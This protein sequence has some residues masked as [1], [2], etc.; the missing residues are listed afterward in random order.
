MELIVA[1]STGK[2]TW[3]QV[4]KLIADMEWTKIILNTNNFGKENYTC[5]KPAE[6]I[7]LDDHAPLEDMRDALIKELKTKVE[8]SEVAVNFISGSGKE[9]MAL[10]G[11]L[12]KS[13]L[14]FRFYASMKDGTKEL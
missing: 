3:G 14:S 13:G 12:L 10:M 4:S 8:G 9:H 1:L 5:T 2:G 11:A 7:V 6:M